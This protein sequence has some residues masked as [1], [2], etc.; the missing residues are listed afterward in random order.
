MSK[1]VNKEQNNADLIWE[2]IKNLPIDMFA[3]PNQ[4]VMNHCT[5]ITVEPSKLYLLVR[6]TATLPA[7]E[8]TLQSYEKMLNIGKKYSVDL[9]DKFVIVSKI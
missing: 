6:S 3:L 9:A 7:L 2:E 8:A 5:P 4:T 1:K